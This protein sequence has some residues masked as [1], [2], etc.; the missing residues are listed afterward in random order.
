M[1]RFRN[2]VHRK[3]LPPK[4]NYTVRNDELIAFTPVEVTSTIV[5]VKYTGAVNKVA[6]VG[7]VSNV[8]EIKGFKATGGA[9]IVRYIKNKSDPIGENSMG[10]VKKWGLRIDFK[11]PVSTAYVSVEKNDTV[12]ITS[13]GPY[14]R[15]LR[16]LHKY[17]FPGIFYSAVKVSKIDGRTHVDA[18]IDLEE[19]GR[20][21]ANK[22]PRSVGYFSYERELYAGGQLNW[23]SPKVSLI[24]FNNGT[25]LFLG[26]KSMDVVK[27]VQTIFKELFYKYGVDMRGTLQRRM[28][29]KKPLP[30][31]KNLAAKRKQGAGRY[32]TAYGYGDIKEGFY[33]RPG[34]NKEPRFY[35][36]PSP[37]KV[38]LVR[39]KVLR[40]YTNAGVPIPQHVKNLFGFNASVQLKEKAEIRRASNWSDV[41]AGFYVRPGPGGLPYFYKVPKG[42]AAGR[43]TVIAAYQTANRRIPSPVRAIFNIPASLAPKHLP[44]EHML[45]R[46]AKGQLRLNG[47]QMARYTHEQLIKVARNLNIPGANAKMKITALA[48]AIKAKLGSPPVTSAG[49]ADLELNGVPISFLMNGRVMRGKRARQWSTLK[50]AEQNAIAK[51][52]LINTN[53]AN[54]TKVAKKDQYTTILALKEGYNKPIVFTPSPT[55]NRTP[56][57]PV[58]SPPRPAPAPVASPKSV[59]MANLKKQVET[60]FGNK[61]KHLL[62][63][64]DVANLYR[65]IS[66]LP[67]GA[68]GKPLQANVNRTITVF[69]KQLKLDRQYAQVRRNYRNSIQISNNLRR[70]IGSNANVERYKNMAVN[71]MIAPNPKGV[72][73]KKADVEAALKTW[74]R[75]QYPPGSPARAR[76]VENMET[77]EMRMIN[78]PNRSKVPSPRLGAPAVKRISPLKVAKREPAFKRPRKPKAAASP[79][80]KAPLGPAVG[81]IKKPPPGASNSNNNSNSNSRSRS[82]SVNMNRLVK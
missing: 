61:Y 18:S 45:N 71:L 64:H 58:P 13:T 15:V 23:V 67:K 32:E 5:S 62:R 9:A 54:W 48:N 51:A 80:P 4:S 38:P 8:T 66:N 21:L 56:T 49:N 17:Y 30:A 50:A 19:L 82:A 22:L 55:K 35:P 7:R 24:L 36:V 44:V 1:E 39:Q 29:R 63:N 46:N 52:Y 3:V 69:L 10:D 68:R 72:L 42:L 37:S 73:P 76:M 14:E 6:D 11:N 31:R 81:P 74:L 60:A 28:Y 70:Y 27:Q 41:K 26:A 40:A 77:G 33:V 16:F 12:V 78:P 65:E 2:V 59:L 57:P 47:K 75:L 43:K 34:A 25:I 79:P 20:Q 53:Y